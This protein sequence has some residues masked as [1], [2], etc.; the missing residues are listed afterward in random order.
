MAVI[1][2]LFEKIPIRMFNICKVTAKKNRLIIEIISTIVIGCIYF[3]LRSH[4][5]K[6]HKNNRFK[7]VKFKER[8]KKRNHKSLMTFLNGANVRT[9]ATAIFYQRKSIH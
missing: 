7:N 4:I 9:Q 1:Y 2:Y 5:R 8:E 6:S 3:V